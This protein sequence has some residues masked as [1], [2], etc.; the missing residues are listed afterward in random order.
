MTHEEFERLLADELGGEIEPADAARLAQAL[1]AD[2]RRA[3]IAA[4]LYATRDALAAGVPSPQRSETRLSHTAAPWSAP[5]PRR[6]RLPT[7]VLRYAAAIALAFGAGFWSAGYAPRPSDKPTTG[8]GR[9]LVVPEW[10][11]STSGL[12]DRYARATRSYP[13]ASSLSHALLSLARR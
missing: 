2:P 5:A 13:N 6:L 4:Q 9:P 7:A 11:S 3:E 1:Q 12:A 10:P 8:P